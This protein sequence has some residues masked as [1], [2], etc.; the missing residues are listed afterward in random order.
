MKYLSKKVLRIYKIPFSILLFIIL[1]GL[2]HTIK[3]SISYLPNG[4]F[5]PF[6]VGYRH[7]TIVPVWLVS[8]MLSI[9]SYLFLMY[10]IHS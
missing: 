3:P 5:R 6:G 4:G 2:Y 8:I 7:N 10:L 9:I 1:F